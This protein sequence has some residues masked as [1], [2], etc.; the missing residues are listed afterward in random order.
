[1]EILNYVKKWN[2]SD[3]V[4]CDRLNRQLFYSMYRGYSYSPAQ[5]NHSYPEHKPTTDTY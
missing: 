3:S 1:M 2:M 5:T 4:L